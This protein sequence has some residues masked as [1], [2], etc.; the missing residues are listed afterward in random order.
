[1]VLC[2]SS[3]SEAKIGGLQKTDSWLL[4]KELEADLQDLKD[5][6]GE[7]VGSGDD[8]YDDEDIDDEEYD[9]YY[10]EDD[11]LEEEGSGECMLKNK[12]LKINILGCFTQNQTDIE[13]KVIKQSCRQRSFTSAI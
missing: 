2:L 8:E 1:M 13:R 7:D 12:G 9:H 10:E 3:E 4:E 11:D 6:E 5:L